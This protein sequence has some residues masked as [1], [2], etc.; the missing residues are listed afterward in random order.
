M[1]DQL[2]L[3]L[4]PKLHFTRDDFVVGA[5]N[6]DA[7]DFLDGWPDWPAP[8]AAVFGPPGSGK[9]HLAR[10]WAGETGSGILS[11]ASLG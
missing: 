10:I 4:E 11:A 7:V 5:G 9:T 8:A 6:R 2:P 3:P 1:S